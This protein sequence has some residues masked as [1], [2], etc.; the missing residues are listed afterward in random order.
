MVTHKNKNM[1]SNTYVEQ[2][3]NP[4][5]RRQWRV[6]PALKQHCVSRR[7]GLLCPLC[8]FQ[9]QRLPACSAAAME[10]TKPRLRVVRSRVTSGSE[11]DS[12]SSTD[13]E[14]DTYTSA[15]IFAASDTPGA[16]DLGNILAASH[17]TTEP[18]AALASLSDLPLPVP[19][20]PAQMNKDQSVGAEGV[21]DSN[22][23]QLHDI[24]DVEALIF[25]V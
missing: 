6:H 9:M 17:G 11:S 1:S 20:P 15:D 25:H 18:S 4:A 19:P 14:T 16:C 24:S 10:T 23:T 12:D 3:G 13:L 21:G 22:L 5:R 2:T 7:W 8:G